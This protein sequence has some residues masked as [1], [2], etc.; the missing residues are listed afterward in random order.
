ML[1]STYDSFILSIGSGSGVVSNFFKFFIDGAKESLNYLIRLN[2]SQDDLNK[3]AQNDGKLKGVE[4]FNQ[5]FNGRFVSGL[6]DESAITADIKKEAKTLYQKYQT[7]LNKLQKDKEF[8]EKNIFSSKNKGSNFYNEE[9]EKLKNYLGEQQSIIKEAG[10]KQDSLKN[11]I[12]EEVKIEKQNNDSEKSDDKLQ[13]KRDDAEKKRIQHLIENQKLV[14][15]NQIYGYNQEEHLLDENLAHIVTVSNF[16]QNIAN[17]EMQRDKVGIK[18]KASLDLI[19]DDR[20]EK[21]IKINREQSEAIAKAKSD[22]AKFEL[23]LMDEKNKALLESGATLTDLLVEQTKKMIDESLNAHKFELKELL[24]IDEIKL[25]NKIK[26][27]EKLTISE[28]KYLK[29]VIK[30]ET[31]AEK[32][33][34]KL[35]KDNL[36]AKLK[37]IDTEEKNEKAKFKLLDKGNLANSINELKL[38]KKSLDEKK[39]LAKKGSQDEIEIDNALAKNKQDLN[40]LVKKSKEDQLNAGLNMLITVA[41]QESSIGKAAAIAQATIST[42]Q[43]ANNILATASASPET[44]LFPGYPSLMV[45]LT[46]A[47]GLATVGKIAGV[48]FFA[49]GTDDAP[50]TG[51]AIVDEI[52]A[53]IHT[54]SSG[55][56]KSFGSESGAR[57][58]DIVKGD[59]IIPADISA[60]IKQ[61]MYSGFNLNQSQQAQID[62]AEMGKQFGIHA[63]KIISAVNQNGKNQLIVNVAKNNM[64]RVTF[65]GRKV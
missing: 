54:D 3:K 30:L 49:E 15:D 33:K 39:K 41:G 58:T 21:R 45:G 29:G 35:D 14:L 46:I 57:F 20:K 34:K 64:D 59:R 50:Y 6:T 31:D 43:A 18:D 5:K 40:A 28:Q 36:E 23:E 16:K 10:K 11:P 24:S 60:I 37:S 61:N 47:N 19:D 8:G 22:D 9:I 27:N 32:E 56:I 42:F 2:T 63:N 55:K 17:L 62:Y 51:K 52:G 25:Q 4:T 1:K 65:R 12:K 13:K 38:E 7:E 48:S 44:V 26:L 53:E